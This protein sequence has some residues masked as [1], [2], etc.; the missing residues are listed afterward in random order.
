VFI[1]VLMIFNGGKSRIEGNSDFTDF[2]VLLQNYQD[3]K[4]QKNIMDESMF[5][6]VVENLFRVLMHDLF[7]DEKHEQ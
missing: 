5:D 3:R 1:F 4:V 7:E 2:Y 6:I